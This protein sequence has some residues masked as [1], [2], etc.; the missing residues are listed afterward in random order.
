MTVFTPEPSASRAAPLDPLKHVNFLPGMVLGVDEF[1]QEFAYHEGHR[2]WLARDAI[3]Y[4]TVNGLTVKVSRDD[5]KGP[6][7][8]KRFKVMVGAGVALTPQGRLVR[9]C[10]EQCAHLNEWLALDSNR[11]GLARAL[12]SPPADPLRLYLTL[13]YDQCETD[14]VPVPG[15]P[16]RKAD[17]VNQPSRIRDDFHLELRVD[18]PSQ[19]EE[20]ALRDYVAWLRGLPVVASDAQAQVADFLAAIRAAAEG[21]PAAD[22]SPPAPGPLQPPSITGTP[23]DF[24]HG[25]PSLYPAPSGALHLPADRACE[26]LREAMRLWV[27]E[28]RPRWKTCWLAPN[29]GCLEP[30][31]DPAARPEGCLLLAEID[32]S[33]MAQAST[34]LWV[35]TSDSM[36]SVDERRRPFVV[37][38]RMLQ[39]WVACMAA[40][41]S[42]AGGGEGVAGPRGPQ[43]PP[44]PQG[45]QGPQGP[46]GPQGQQGP[47]GLKGDSGT[48]GSPGSGPQ[49][50]KGDAGPQGIQGPKG[51]TGPQGIQGSKGDTG[52]QGIQGPKGDDSKVAGPQGPPGDG[53][54]RVSGWFLTSQF[55]SDPAGTGDRLL[56][57]LFT[58]PKA[59]EFNAFQ[60]EAD[61]FL[62]TWNSYPKVLDAQG[63]PRIVV[64]GTPVVGWSAEPGVHG[65]FEV[66]LPGMDEAWKVL[67]AKVTKSSKRTG[68]LLGGGMQAGILVRVTTPALHRTDQ[69]FMVEISSYPEE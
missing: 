42:G 39:E 28:L 61:L 23:A 34:G 12:G 43:G 29:A 26:F 32:V 51:D 22:G 6:E 44:G 45:P 47:Q 25:D 68:K 57:P 49:G 5:S 52:P 63:L 18:P 1:Q 67:V 66:V 69:G 33:L 54:V 46:P 37:H 7:D 38:Q 8:P 59:V 53:F 20:D 48:S 60:V 15:E 56:R 30:P 41:Q 36:P 2:Q 16:C 19:L 58:Y 14:E 62:L 50:P 24:L 4:G 35:V 31:S 13:C 11:G 40:S 21:P 65:T 9:V 64:K 27:T 10:P 3:G 55:L 17:D